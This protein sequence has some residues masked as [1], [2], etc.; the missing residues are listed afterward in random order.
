MSIVLSNSVSLDETVVNSLATS[1]FQPLVRV[2]LPTGALDVSV[3]KDNSFLRKT[4]CS[5]APEGSLKSFS[6]AHSKTSVF[7][8]PFAMLLEAKMPKTEETGAC[9]AL[10][11]LIYTWH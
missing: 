5:V 7:P 10:F 4:G 8:P 1:F 6:Y 2:S 9:C 3:C 11:I